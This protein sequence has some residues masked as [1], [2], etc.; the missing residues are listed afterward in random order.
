MLDFFRVFGLWTRNRPS[1]Q[2]LAGLL[3]KVTD[4]VRNLATAGKRSRAIQVYRQQT[5]AS[6]HQALRVVNELMGMGE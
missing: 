4:D 1:K 6:L 5:G 2:G 3:D